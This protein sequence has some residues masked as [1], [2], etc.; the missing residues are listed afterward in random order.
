MTALEA[1]NFFDDKNIKIGLQ[2]LIDVGLDYVSLGQT[3]DTLSV[4]EAQRLKLASR[5]Q[6]KGDIIILDEPTSGLHFADVAKLLVLLNKSNLNFAV[7]ILLTASLIL[8]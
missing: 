2:M 4:G 5:L 7:N 8:F 3:L 1:I 6:N